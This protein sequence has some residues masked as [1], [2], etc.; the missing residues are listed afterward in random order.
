MLGHSLVLVHALVL[1]NSLAVN[2]LIGSVSSPA[3]VRSLVVNSPA[4][5]LHYDALDL[6][7]DCSFAVHKNN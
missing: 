6:N 2:N 1:V 5:D 3:L 7:M 4:A